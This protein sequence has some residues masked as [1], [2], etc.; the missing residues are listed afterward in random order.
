MKKR[1]L[2]LAACALALCAAC[3]DREPEVRNVI[4]LIGDGMGLAQ[5]SLLQVAE[6]YRP[7]A[8]D[9]AHNVALFTTRS[10]NP[11]PTRPPPARR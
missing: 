8:F 11:S 7:T 6:E 3:T 4:Y 2:T 5:V 9:R 10:A 1:F